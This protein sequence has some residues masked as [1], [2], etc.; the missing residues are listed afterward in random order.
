MRTK[1]QMQEGL[2][3][4][5]W[6]RTTYPRS[7]RHTHL[8][9]AS[10]TWLIST[11]ERPEV[12]YNHPSL[13]VQ[14]RPRQVIECLESSSNCTRMSTRTINRRCCTATSTFQITRV[15]ANLTRPTSQIIGEEMEAPIGSSRC[16]WIKG[17]GLA[18]WIRAALENN[19]CTKEI[20]VKMCKRKERSTCHWSARGRTWT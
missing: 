11:E 19:N 5:A 20:W 1:C 15:R 9:W 6:P 4:P 7:R 16:P 10:F 18:I 8:I 3:Q 14:V 17:K 12:A 13:V 2:E